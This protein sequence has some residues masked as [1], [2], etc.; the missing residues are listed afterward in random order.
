MTSSISPTDGKQIPTPDSV[1]TAKIHGRYRES[2]IG[3]MM[4]LSFSYTQ[5]YVSSEPVSSDWIAQ[6]NSHRRLMS[7]SYNVISS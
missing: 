7:K 6:I 2:P 4:D 5:K 3:S 1:S